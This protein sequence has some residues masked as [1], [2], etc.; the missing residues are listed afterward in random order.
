MGRLRWTAG[1]LAVLLALPL[2][3]FLVP[4]SPGDLAHAAEPSPRESLAGSRAGVGRTP[5]GRELP[6]P[7][8]SEPEPP[9]SEPA[10]TPEPRDTERPSAAR[11]PVVQ[12]GLGG[13]LANVLPLGAGLLLTGLGIAFLAL[14]L[15][16]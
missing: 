4:G 7:E 1:T 11:Q 3:L 14:R 5:P 9:P 8:E 13:P 16:R 6:A 15:R 2:L 10:A 12:R